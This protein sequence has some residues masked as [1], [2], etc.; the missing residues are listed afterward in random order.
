MKRILIADAGKASLVMTSEVFKD[1][2]PGV[3]VVVARTSAEVLDT[4]KTDSAFDAVVV[5]Y[6]LPDRDGADTAARI[7]KMSQVPVL[8][9]GFERPGVT[10]AIEEDLAGYDDCL[11]WL[12]KPVKAEL[13]VAIAQRYCEGKYRTQRRV[14][15]AFPALFE[16][17]VPV[18]TTIPLP[19]VKAK[20]VQTAAKKGAK[21]APKKGAKTAGKA[22]AKDVK[23]APPRVKTVTTIKRTW[24]PAW[25]E[26]CSLGGVKVRVPR[27]KV[28]ALS[29]GKHAS[30]AVSTLN[31]GEIL[32]IQIPCIQQIVEAAPLSHNQLSKDLLSKKQGPASSAKAKAAPV[33]KV[34]ASKAAAVTN[35]LTAVRGRVAWTEGSKTSSEWIFGI[36]AEN[37]SLS[38]KIFD[39]VIE[40]QKSLTRSTHSG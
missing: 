35:T 28:E 30:F 40:S 10:D 12:R 11:N 16:M 4:I 37:M 39:A 8:L 21:V 14:A 3:Q 18:V 27:H 23:V 7:K 2:F 13:V 6:D 33:K 36:Q 5:D 9:T 38:K 24:I 26:D 22:S 34:A 25:V 32:N 20:M 17:A 19:P 15:C 29:L 1:H 31:A